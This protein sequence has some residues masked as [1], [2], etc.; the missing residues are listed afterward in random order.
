MRAITFFIQAF[1]GRNCRAVEKGTEA[2]YSVAECGG[3]GGFR[4]LVLRDDD[5]SS[6]TLGPW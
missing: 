5:R 1:V 6:L 3:V 4:L 2:T